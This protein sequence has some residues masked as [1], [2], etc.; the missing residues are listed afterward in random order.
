MSAY[1]DQ[2]RK[3]P[4]LALERPSR[5]V[6]PRLNLDVMNRT[7]HHHRDVKKDR[8]AY[9]ERDHRPSHRHPQGDKRSVRQQTLSA[10]D[11]TYGIDGDF[12][13]EYFDDDGF[14][15]ARAQL[16]THDSSDPFSCTCFPRASN[17][18]IPSMMYDEVRCPHP[19]HRYQPA[20]QDVFAYPWT[21][22]TYR[23]HR[24]P[25]PRHGYSQGQDRPPSALTAPPFVL[26]NTK[27]GHPSKGG[28]PPPYSAPDPP[29][30][31]P[32]LSAKPSDRRLRRM[33]RQRVA[34]GFPGLATVAEKVN[35]DV[36]PFDS[37]SQ[38]GAAETAPRSFRSPSL[39]LRTVD[40]PVLRRVESELWG[41]GGRQRALSTP[42]ALPVLDPD[43]F[44]ET[45]NRIFKGEY[46]D[47]RGQKYQYDIK[48]GKTILDGKRTRLQTI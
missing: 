28:K 1:H 25:P 15:A 11:S 32:L 8:R 19:E 6:V 39:R 26:Y 3:S 12:I 23:P 2:G 44:P 33:N 48:Y 22:Q 46:V 37:V 30:P 47:S 21:S 10:R 40:S 9:T 41:H 24:E 13:H 14:S 5:V 34:D 45:P 4:Q 36:F 16:F 20:A 27:G 29:L 17:K 42:R 35:D 18:T 31:A 43:G 38:V 7:R